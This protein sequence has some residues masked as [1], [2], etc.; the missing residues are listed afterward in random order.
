MKAVETFDLTRV[1]R[2]GRGIVGVSLEIDEG[3][4]F[5]FLGPGG[6]GKTTL[7]EV[8]AT[9]AEPTSGRFRIMGL[10]P[11]TQ[12]AEIRKGMGTL[13]GDPAHVPGRTGF[14]NALMCARSREME[15][16]DAEK[17]VRELFEH[18]RMNDV[19]DFPAGEYSRS[20]QRKL[21]IIEA[22]CH[23]PIV[24]LLDDPSL[25]L[26]YPS[27]HTLHTFLHDLADDGV[28]V[29]LATND[30]FEAEALCDRVAFV[31]RGAIVDVNTPEGYLEEVAGKSRVSMSLA[32]PASADLLS[33]VKGI[34]D[35]LNNNGSLYVLCDSDDAVV[36]NLA[37]TLKEQGA[38]IGNIEVREPNLGDVFLM[39]T[40][41]DW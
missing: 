27:E 14:D 25:G 5:G 30:V 39:K 15:A 24:L 18:F 11:A 38:E 17:H 33:S 12:V 31:Y 40:A 1:H 32:S 6:S 10:D 37:D 13:L 19:M 41:Q 7:L 3:E 35:V 8:L 23:D 20:L 21:A 26:D 22:V 36:E 4:V 28:T 2:S 16:A 9:A 29:L 34:R